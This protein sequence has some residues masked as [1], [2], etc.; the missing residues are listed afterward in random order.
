MA[1]KCK[2]PAKLAEELPQSKSFL[3]L[4]GPYQI[5]RNI[6]PY[7]IHRKIKKADLLLKNITTINPIIGV[8]R[9][10]KN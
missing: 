1:K 6:G 3:Y 2:L 7:Q 5:H 9:N 8:V 10:N 4:I